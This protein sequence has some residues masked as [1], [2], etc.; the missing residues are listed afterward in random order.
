MPGREGVGMI[1]EGLENF[2]FSILFP[3][4]TH[5]PLYPSMSTGYGYAAVSLTLPQ[6]RHVD[7]PA[8]EAPR[9]SGAFT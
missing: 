1:A 2:A 3:T 6:T 5:H 8:R 7:R 4:L 9:F